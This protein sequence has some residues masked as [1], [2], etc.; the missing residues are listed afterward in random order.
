MLGSVMSAVEEGKG[1]PCD[2]ATVTSHALG[3]V[4][5]LKAATQKAVQV[6]ESFRLCN[7]Q[8]RVRWHSG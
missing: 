2:I 8:E 3:K 7:K 5:R 6:S 1:H 4:R